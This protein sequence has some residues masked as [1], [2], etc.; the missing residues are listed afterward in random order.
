[1]QQFRALAVVH[2][3]PGASLSI[4]AGHL[5]LTTASASKLIES[6]VKQALVTRVDSPADRR[7]ITLDLTESGRDALV[8]ARVAALGRLDELLAGLDK[9]DRAAVA[10]AM[11]VLRQALGQQ[12]ALGNGS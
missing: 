2:R 9:P 4:V 12:P 3:H 1:M 7:M 8:A 10:R 11:E 6:L 5:G